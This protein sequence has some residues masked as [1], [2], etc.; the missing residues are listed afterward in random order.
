MKGKVGNG[1]MMGN[2]VKKKKGEKKE[3]EAKKLICEIGCLKC[4]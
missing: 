1:G 2:E 4:G 3:N